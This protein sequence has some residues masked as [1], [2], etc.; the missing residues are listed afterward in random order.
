MGD[1]RLVDARSISLLYHG[2]DNPALVMSGYAKIGRYVVPYLM[3]AGYDVRLHTPVGHQMNVMRWPDPRSGKTLEMWSG[4]D[5]PY[6]ESI[7][8][9]HMAKLHELSGKH[10]FLLFC[11]DVVALNEIPKWAAEKR[12]TA[13]AWGAVDWEWPTPKHALDK[14]SPFFRVFPFSHHGYRVLEQDGLKNLL[15]PVW[16]GVDTD[17]FKPVARGAYPDA[18]ASM[19]FRLD[20]FNVF[21]CFANQFLR[22]GEAEMFMA[23]AEF[24]KRHPEAKIHFFAFTQVRREWDLAALVDHLGIRDLVTFSDD[25]AHVMGEYAEED[26]AAMM[27]SSDCVMSVGYEGFGLQ[28]CEA[29]SCER[30][31]IGFN[32]GATPEILGEGLLVP[33]E[34]EFL[35]NTMFRRPL[36]NGLKLVEA[37]EYVW[38]NREHSRWRKGRKW[39]MDNLK[40]DACG[41]A[42]VARMDAVEQAIADEEVLGPPAPGK[43][44]LDRAGRKVVVEAEV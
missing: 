18:M 23:V 32:A 27:A 6:G 9:A 14:F 40:W 41:K 28:T 42:L 33:P 25:Y 7:V 36:P 5:G 44:G 38:Q 15:P 30:P 1:S 22:K 3:D 39:V 35:M 21:S 2:K 10:P 12:I 34:K 17:V 19:G 37:L 31:V 43:L 20:G 11:G 26:V 4:G 29:Q 24:H 13:A 8:P 16:C